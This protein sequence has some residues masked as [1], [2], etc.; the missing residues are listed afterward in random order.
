MAER[1][2]AH[3]SC[4]RALYIKSSDSLLFITA[5]INNIHDVRLSFQQA[6][7][8]DAIVGFLGILH[9]SV[10]FQRFSFRLT[11]CTLML[12][13]A[14]VSSDNENTIPVHKAAI[15]VLTAC[16]SRLLNQTPAFGMFLTEILRQYIQG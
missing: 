4:R 5:E 13:K 7:C 1:L 8:R 10:M 6:R 14:A 2:E 11:L 15:K 16:A 12:P 3:V 9:V